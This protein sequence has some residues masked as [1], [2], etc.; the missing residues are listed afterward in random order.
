MHE[1]ILF[2]RVKTLIGQYDQSKPFA[3]Y[4][5]DF[6]KK[7]PQMGARDRRETRDYCFHFLRLG[8]NLF[9]L[10][11]INRLAVASFL[12]S[13]KKSQ[14]LEILLHQ[15]SSFS[16][17]QIELPIEEKI[18]IVENVHTDFNLALIFFD[19][20]LLEKSIDQI[21]FFRS[22]LIQPLVWVR[23]KTGCKN[24]FV[25]ELTEKNIPYREE[26]DLIFSFAAGQSLEGLASFTNGLFEIQDLNSGNI[27]NFLH[28]QKDDKWW[29]VCAASGGKSLLLVDKQPDIFILATDVREN[30]LKNYSLR[31]KK[32]GFQGYVKQTI[33]LTERSIN[34][35]DRFDGIIAD[36]PCSG[37]GTWARSPENLMVDH[38]KN[39]LKFYQPLQRKIV[40]NA[41]EHLKSDG[42][43]IYSTCSVFTAENTDNVNY[44]LQHLSLELV[45]TQLLKGYEIKADSLFVAIFRKVTKNKE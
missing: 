13:A 39:V 42:I 3:I 41:V 33:D 4:L 12:C 30:I 14:S 16:I 29:D 38:E 23:V 21:A 27:G 18:K 25:N 6:F 20:E 2:D 8:R 37:S 34:P 35:S 26:D 15:H 7:N 28:P 44:F 5:K 19:K 24:D 36:V 43:F 31:M 45:E 22:F 32:I 11:F 1:N 9:G 40:T 10:E 17:E